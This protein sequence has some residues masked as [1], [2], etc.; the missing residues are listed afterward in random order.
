M[1]AQ[2]VTDIAGNVPRLYDFS[3]MA[4]TKLVESGRAVRKFPLRVNRGHEA[5]ATLLFGRDAFYQYL[6]AVSPVRIVIEG[7]RV[8]GQYILSLGYEYLQP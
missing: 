8:E 7:S 3:Q 4:A 2:Y 6:H 5:G 1:D